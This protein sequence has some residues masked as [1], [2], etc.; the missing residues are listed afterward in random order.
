MLH[1][2]LHHIFLHGEITVHLEFHALDTFL[3]RKHR[4]APSHLPRTAHGGCMRKK[5]FFFTSLVPRLPCERTA[6][7][8]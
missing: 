7:D 4:S 6:N 1:I 5:V 2:C 3:A 8:L